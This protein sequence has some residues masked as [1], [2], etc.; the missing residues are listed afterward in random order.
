M[1]TSGTAPD[2]ASQTNWFTKFFSKPTTETS[3]PVSA[4]EP[5]PKKPANGQTVLVVDDDPLFLKI[6]AT[7]L[8]TDGYTVIMAKDGSEAI[9]AVRKQKPNLV[10]LDVNLP[11]DFAGVPWDGF[12]VIQWLKRFESLKHIPVVMVTSGDPSKHAREAIRAGATAFFHKRMDQSHLIT[13]VK[14]TLLRRKPALAAGLD[15]NFSI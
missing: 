11:Q 5:T 10:V 4:S 9:E 8:E 14:Q 6:A 1:K 2:Q 15:T 3:A 7:R 12:R 13:M